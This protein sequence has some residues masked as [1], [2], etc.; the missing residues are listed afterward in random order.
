MSGVSERMHVFSPS[1]DPFVQEMVVA[2]GQSSEAAQCEPVWVYVW[3][4]V[5]VVVVVVVGEGGRGALC[6]FVCECEGVWELG[7]MLRNV[8]VTCGVGRPP[9][10]LIACA[11][12]DVAADSVLGCVGTLR[13]EPPQREVAWRRERC[14][15]LGVCVC[16]CVCVCVYVCVCVCVCVCVNTS[17]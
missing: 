17:V 10:E 11:D 9:L 13:L 8:P 16:V 2:C 15:N 7:E 1:C 6:V 14:A 3:V 12:G 4:C 5:L